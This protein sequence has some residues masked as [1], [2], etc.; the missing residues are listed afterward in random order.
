MTRDSSAFF[1]LP[2]LVASVDF[3]NDGATGG[4]YGLHRGTAPPEHVLAVALRR[5]HEVESEKSV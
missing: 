1:M 4:R 5:Y 3:G 2:S